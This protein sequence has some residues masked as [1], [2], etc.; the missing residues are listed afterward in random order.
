MLWIQTCEVQ[1]QAVTRSRGFPAIQH[2]GLLPTTYALSGES[3]GNQIAVAEPGDIVRARS[4]KS[5][6]LA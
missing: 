1:N 3:A 4:A 5:Q 2:D 6:T